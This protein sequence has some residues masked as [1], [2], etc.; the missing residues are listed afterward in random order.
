MTPTAEA[1]AASPGLALRPRPGG[2][3][4]GRGLV[5][6]YLSLIVLIPLA[7]VVARSTE[8]GMGAFWTSVT[9][10][11]AVAVMERRLGEA[12]VVVRPRAA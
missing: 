1:H 4:I 6:A 11:E 12:A 10:P 3:A 7:A 8:D 2:A 5:T 9:N